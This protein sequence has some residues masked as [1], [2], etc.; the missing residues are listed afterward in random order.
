VPAPSAYADGA[1]VSVCIGGDLDTCAGGTTVFLTDSQINSG[2]YDQGWTTYTYRTAPGEQSFY[3]FEGWTVR[4]VMAAAGIDPDTAENFSVQRIDGTWV[5]LTAADIADPPDFPEGPAIIWTDGIPPSSYIFFRPVRDD[6]DVNYLDKVTPFDGTPLNVN[7]QLNG[8]QLDVQAACAHQKVHAGDSDTCFSSVSNPVDGETYSSHW[9]WTD[10][11][12]ENGD[13]I[14]RAFPSVGTIAGTVTV[15]GSKG[16]GGT[17]SVTVVVDKAPGS[18]G[19][20]G[21]S[22]HHHHPVGGAPGGGTPG[23][24][25]SSPGSS[26]SGPAPT[27]TQA[28][29]PGSAPSARTAADQITGTLLSARL[30]ADI[31]ART[32]GGADGPAGAHP[33]SSHVS[34]GAVAGGVGFALFAAGA[35]AEMRRDRRSPV[36]RLRRSRRGRRR[37]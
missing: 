28:A 24:P 3:T 8:V 29:A 13:S 23:P 20:P 1:G 19:P 22:N 12:T 4:T 25:S 5:T 16:S 33:P 26:G 27:P 37:R 6:Q 14:T 2:V 10:G 11:R 15:T 21:G 31:A 9:E 32:T 35:L 17:A 7:I 34:P 18:P 30:I 36:T